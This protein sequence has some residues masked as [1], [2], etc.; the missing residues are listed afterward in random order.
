MPLDRCKAV[1]ACVMRLQD[2]FWAAK[3]LA[4][5]FRNKSILSLSPGVEDKCGC[6]GGPEHQ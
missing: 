4:R 5:T 1:L 3:G 2:I 6:S